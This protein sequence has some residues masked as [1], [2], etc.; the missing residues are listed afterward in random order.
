MA[1]PYVR[2]LH[3]YPESHKTVTEIT[4]FSPPLRAFLAAPDSDSIWAA[5]TA[6][7]R[8][9]VHSLS[10]GWLFPGVTVVLLAVLGLVG[11]AY[12]R[13]LR[14]G[15]ALGTVA[16]WFLSQGLPG[17]EHPTNGFSLY[18]LLYDYGPG[19]DGVRTPGR[20]NTLTSLGLALLAAA[21]V[22][23]VQ[24]HLRRLTP[25]ASVAACAILVAA[26]LAEGFG[27]LPHPRLPSPQTAQDAPSPQLDLP[28]D[29]NTEPLN[30]YWS[31][32]GFPRIAN[33]VGSFAPNFYDQIKNPSKTFPDA[34]SVA[35]LRR[36]GIRSVVLHLDRA[37]GT[38]WQDVA[39]RPVA[40][41]GITR[42]EEG[43]LVVYR[44]GP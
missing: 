25:A 12:S 1:Q 9:S 6:H 8:N 21:G 34:A 30:V 11:G 44:L 32:D 31:I 7:W 22:V 23:F 16:C 28:A 13:R 39:S 3:N 35:A 37:P 38:D 33:G 2:V 27:P 5:A 36:L 29:F 14:L 10:E 42:Q 26:I 40:G 17:E 24:R 19:W 41:L 18:R 15:L 20:I 43:G 4:H